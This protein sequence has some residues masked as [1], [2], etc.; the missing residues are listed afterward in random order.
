[1]ICETEI[2]IIYEE[3]N[4]MPSLAFHLCVKTPGDYYHVPISLSTF[5]FSEIISIPIFKI[6]HNTYRKLG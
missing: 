1:M 3:L 4:V 6:L 5:E 2:G